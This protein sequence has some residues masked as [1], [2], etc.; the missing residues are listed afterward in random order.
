MQT[1]KLAIGCSI[2]GVDAKSLAPGQMLKIKDLLYKN[3]LIVLKD[4]SL[5]RARIL[6]FR[7]PLRLTCPLPAGQLPPPRIPADLRLLQRQE[8]RQTD[9]RRPHRRLLALR[10]LLRAR[11]Q[12]HHHADAEGSAE[13]VRAQH[14]FHRYGRGLCGASRRRPRTGS[15]AP[16]SCIRAACAS[17]SAPTASAR[18]LRNPLHDR[19][20][21]P[22]P[23][24]HPGVIEHPYTKEKVIYGNRGFTIGI[25]NRSLDESASASARD[26]RLRRNRPLRPRSSV[27]DGRHHHLGQ[28]LPSAQLGPQPGT[29]GRDHDVPHHPARRHAALRQPDAD[30]NRCLRIGLTVHLFPGRQRGEQER[31]IVNPR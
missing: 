15:P 27:V 14:P 5:T 13:D 8:R 7:Q 18:H 22:R 24:R 6:R 19:P 23:S 11:P 2:H 29:R 31:R 21:S 25:A 3:R 20:G 4:Q 16:S 17:R 12:V 28:P 1:G 30:Q 10:H 26:L 9:R